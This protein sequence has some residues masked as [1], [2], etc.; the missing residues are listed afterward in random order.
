VPYTGYAVENVENVAAVIEADTSDGRARSSK[1]QLFRKKWI[2]K[3]PC[4]AEELK[5][6]PFGNA[7]SRSNR[8]PFSVWSH[9]TQTLA[10][11][12]LYVRFEEGIWPPLLSAGGRF[13]PVAPFHSSSSPCPQTLVALV[14][15]RCH[16]R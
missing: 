8:E 15:S 2:V 13:L 11:A 7:H 12:G 9:G 3:I 1:C 10:C 14:P 4:L 16:H 5:R 6:M